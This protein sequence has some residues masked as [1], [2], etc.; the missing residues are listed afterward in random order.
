MSLNENAEEH[1]EEAELLQSVPKVC[2]YHSRDIAP[3]SDRHM[4]TLPLASAPSTC[5]GICKRRE[6]QSVEY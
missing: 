4:M 3:Q 2:E 1:A 6:N 5:T